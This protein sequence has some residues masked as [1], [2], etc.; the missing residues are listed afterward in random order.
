MQNYD[1]VF[2][3]GWAVF[4]YHAH[5]SIKWLK[6]EYNDPSKDKC[7][8]L[9]PCPCFFCF[10][11][12]VFKC[13]WK[14]HFGSLSI[15]SDLKRL[16]F[17]HDCLFACRASWLFFDPRFSS[18][19]LV[20]HEKLHRSPWTTAQGPLAPFDAFLT[21]PFSRHQFPGTTPKDIKR[22]R[23]SRTALFSSFVHRCF[24]A[25]CPESGSI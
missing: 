13:R 14:I 3:N 6:G 1:N 15:L 20:L 25:V 21:W 23:W 7:W 16:K 8:K 9:P 22:P 2:T 5:C 11:S 19:H 10:E 12:V 17:S 24:T 18:F 4:W